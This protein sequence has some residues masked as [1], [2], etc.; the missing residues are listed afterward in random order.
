MLSYRSVDVPKIIIIIDI[1]ARH[2]YKLENTKIFSNFHLGN[3]RL[4]WAL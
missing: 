3:L 4:S 2:M 1:E